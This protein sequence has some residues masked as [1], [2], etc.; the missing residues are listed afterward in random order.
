ME[1]FETLAKLGYGEL[2]FG[3]D[4]ATGLRALVGI[5]STRLGPSIGGTR[6]RF[7]DSESDAIDDV[8]RLA[9]GMAYKAA[10]AKLPHGGGKAV[11]MAPADLAK[12]PAEKRAALFRAFGAFVDNLGGRYITTEDSGTSTSDM[13]VVRTSTKHVLGTSIDKG[14]SGDPSPFTALGCRR[15]IE[16]IANHVFGKPDLKGLHVAVQGVGHVG[17]HLARELVQAGAKLTI[18]DVDP[19]RRSAVAAELGAAVVDVDQILE[20]DCD[21]VAPCAL[22][23]ALTEAVLPKLKC[24]AVAGAAN[25]QLRTPGVGKALHARGIFYAPDYVINGGGLINVA[26]EYAGYDAAAARAKTIAIYDTIKDIIDRS[27]RE[28]TQPEL[29]ADRIAEE[30][31]AAGTHK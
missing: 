16:A 12:W 14:G 24:K 19:A 18:C 26:Q 30:T 22:G 20:V 25:N 10:V 17:A 27:R 23:G 6:I 9:Q 13:D 7:Y 5:H 15:G 11:I 29:I 1:I 21:I 4:A 2:H 28:K 3:H 8:T 31:I